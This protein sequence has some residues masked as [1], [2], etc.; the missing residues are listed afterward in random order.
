VRLSRSSALPARKLARCRRLS[1]SQY[2]FHLR[3]A[4]GMADG[5]ARGPGSSGRE[6][7]RCQSFNRFRRRP[8][9]RRSMPCLSSASV[10]TLIK[11]RSSS[12]SANQAT[13]PGFGYG[14]IHSDTRLVSSRKFTNQ[15]YVDRPWNASLVPPSRAGVVQGDASIGGMIHVKAGRSSREDDIA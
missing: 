13:T 7:A 15:L 9:C 10:T 12:A 8:A 6:D 3:R 1:P 11:T 14:R 2:N 4:N 5:R